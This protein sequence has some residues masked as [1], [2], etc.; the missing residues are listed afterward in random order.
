MHVRP[1]YHTS[2]NREANQLVQMTQQAPLFSRQ[3][4]LGAKHDS[5]MGTLHI[6]RRRVEWTPDAIPAAQPV[7]YSLSDVVGTHSTHGRLAATQRHH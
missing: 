3:A 1:K 2:I 7:L 6:G 5:P 4:R